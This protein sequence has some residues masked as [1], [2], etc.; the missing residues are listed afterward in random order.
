MMDHYKGKKIN[1]T[2]NIK[3]IVGE[4][5]PEQKT[6]TQMIRLTFGAVFQV[7]YQVAMVADLGR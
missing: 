4:G 7:S 6:L 3:L 5:T 1:M 2:F